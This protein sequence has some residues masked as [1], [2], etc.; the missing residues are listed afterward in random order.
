MSVRASKEKVQNSV[1]RFPLLPIRDAVIFPGHVHSLLITREH[2]RRTIHQAQQDGSHVI[3]VTQI[4]R[5]TEDP[6]LSE[7]YSVGVSCEIMHVTPLPDGSIRAVL[8]AGS[9]MQVRSVKKTTKMWIAEAQPF[10]SAAIETDELVAVTRFCVAKFTELAEA[11]STIPLESLASFSPDD[12]SD[13]IIDSIS[14]F[15]STTIAAKQALLE[16]HDV[17]NRAGELSKILAREV[18]LHEIQ[19]DVAKSVNQTFDDAQREY[20]LREQLRSIQRELGDVESNSEAERHR[21]SLL[22]NNPP[23]VVAKRALDEIARLE[24]FQASGPESSMID[25]YLDWILNLPWNRVSNEDIDI[26]EAKGILDEAHH[27]LNEVKQRVVEYLAVQKL[28]RS[29]GGQIL[30]FVGPPGV[31]KTS[32]AESIA[33]AMNRKLARVALGGVRDEAEIRGHRRTYVGAQPGRIIKEIRRAGSRSI[34]I[35]LDEIDKISRESRGDPTSALLEVLDPAIQ[36]EFV[37][38]YLDMPF[39]LSDIVFLATANSVSEILPALLDRMEIVEF[40]SYTPSERVEIAK[41]YMMPKLIEEHGIGNG[42]FFIDDEAIEKI[43]TLYTNE[44]GV[45]QLHQQLAAICRKAAVTILAGESVKVDCNNL[46]EWICTSDY[47]EP[48]NQLPKVGSCFGLAVCSLGGSSMPIEVVLLEPEGTE[49]KILLTGNLGEVMRESAQAGVTYLRS[50]SIELLG[51]KNVGKDIHVHVGEGGV[52]KDGPSAGLA[53]AIA[54]ISAATNR[55][56]RSGIAATGEIGLA[57]DIRPVGGLREKLIA[58]KRDGFNTVLVPKRNERAILE[59]PHDVRIGI[60]I[61]YVAQLDEALSVA[62]EPSVA[63]TVALRR[64][65]HAAIGTA[66][67]EATNA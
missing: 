26:N 30:C 40:T 31:G 29:I 35:L 62:L 53:V 21:N 7:L 5:T 60:D 42:K 28:S 24:R 58:A 45:R 66:K 1:S 59:L 8:R 50:H 15:L 17:L 39:D 33:K 34:V 23:E 48:K 22:A 2:S 36:S 55:A 12:P 64:T 14:Y 13:R 38:H 46:H 20:F 54:L 9:R 67:S 10:T 57:G 49:S 37:D 65:T 19:Q 44:P 61:V 52:P 32:A 56:V 4:N 16:E 51:S 6:R 3:C 25:S 18:R 47:Q 63:G 11:D 27:G 43:A 41:R